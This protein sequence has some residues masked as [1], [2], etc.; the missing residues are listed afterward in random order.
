M[1]GSI[2]KRKTKSGKTTYQA[3]FEEGYSGGKRIRRYQTYPTYRQAE[4][5]LRAMRQKPSTSY[6]NCSANIQPNER[7]VQE[8]FSEWIEV[9]SIHIAENTKRGYKNYLEKYIYPHLGNLRIQ[10]LTA[11][12]LNGFYADLRKE[13]LNGRSV[14]Y[15][16]AT[17]HLALKYA[18]LMQYVGSNAAD[19][20][21][22]LKKNA[23]RP[24]VYSDAQT[25]EL[26]K[27]S[28]QTIYE[29]PV[30][31]AVYLGLR[32]GEVLGLQWKDVDL[33]NKSIQIRSNLV[34]IDG[35]KTICSP[36]TEAGN[37]V[38]AVP[39]ELV[40]K[41]KEHRTSQKHA[42]HGKG[43]DYVCCRKDGEP[44]NTYAFSVMFSRFLK[45]KGLPHCRF[46]DLRHI[47]ATLLLKS[48]VNMKTAQAR[49]GHSDISTTM[50][51]YTHVDET[52]QS[53]PAERMDAWLF[54]V[55]ANQEGS[56]E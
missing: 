4:E 44:Y 8:V 37:R 19:Q 35:E 54:D 47:H 49:L 56:N 31:L 55:S 13:G 18:V 32:R 51:I 7:T 21:T 39:S 24:Y 3:V 28:E 17:I 46:H 42:H 48:G 22:H 15:C 50:N 45:R 41:L 20:V 38:I 16:H 27:A 1:N 53:D 34:C 10:T 29:I 12:D 30:Y 33:K 14:Q 11:S 52:M 26:L 2:R 40:Q 25:L 6:A 9:H 5:A 43:K 36:K 23:Y